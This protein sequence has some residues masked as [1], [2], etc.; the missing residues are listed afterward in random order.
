MLTKQ[1]LDQIRKVVK[2]EV[3][4]AIEEFAISLAPTFT[5]IFERFDKIEVR[6]DRIEVRLDKI[7]AEIEKLKEEVNDLGGQIDVI[8]RR[9]NALYSRG[10]RH[11]E[12]I[13]RVERELH[14]PAFA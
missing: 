5:N 2:E 4:S 1:D 7:E 14:L 6:L 12:R 11:G 3:N 13:K 9:I 10:N 8:E